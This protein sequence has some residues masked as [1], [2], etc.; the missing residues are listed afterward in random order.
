MY[1]AILLLLSSNFV[2]I[3]CIFGILLAILISDKN[4]RKLQKFFKVL[5]N[6]TKHAG[7]EATTTPTTTIV[8]RAPGP[9]PLPI[10]GNLACLDGYEVPYQAFSVLREKYGDIISLKLGS[11]PTLVVNGIDN[12]KEVMVKKGAHFDGRPNFRR[13]HQL[14]SGNK[15]NCKLK[16]SKI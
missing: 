5:L 15:E 12:I 16:H 6:D 9:M 13:Y 4:A 10:I 3:T 1:N 7:I 2:Y 11:V 8:N 14:F